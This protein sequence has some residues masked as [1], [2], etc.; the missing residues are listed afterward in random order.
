MVAY[1]TGLCVVESRIRPV[2]LPLP[3]EAGC[4]AVRDSE[5]TINAIREQRNF[6][7]ANY[8]PILMKSCILQ[9]N[10]WLAYSFTMQQHVDGLV[11]GAGTCDGACIDKEDLVGI[12]DGIKAMSDDDPGRGIRQ[13]LQAFSP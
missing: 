4:W 3:V 12:F 13:F 8:H 6:M 11:Q 1:S 10:F 2:I 5:K 9:L 7:D